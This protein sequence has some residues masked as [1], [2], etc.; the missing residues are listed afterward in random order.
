MPNRERQP[1]GSILLW[2][3]ALLVMLGSAVWQRKTGPTHPQKGEVE[4][5]G[6]TVPYTLLRSGT[7]G[8]PLRV[9]VG[10]P[11][12]VTG[13]I[14][15]RRYPTDEPFGALTMLRDGEVL[16]GLLPTQPPAGKL[17]YQLVLAG[18]FGL[19]RIPADEPV[20]MRFKDSVPA[21]ALIPH[22]LL[23]FLAM[24]IGVRAGL[25]A[26]L[27]RPETKRLA[28][29]TL[30]G[31]TVGGMIL[32]PVVQKYAFG[33]FWTGWPFGYDLTDNK[34]LVM[35][36][37]WL[38]AV[39]VL[40]YARGQKD[41]FARTVVAMATVV[42]IAVYLVPHSLRGSQLDYDKLDA[43]ESAHDAIGTGR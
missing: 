39:L 14:R 24:L 30:A 9:T 16:V 12:E 4:I 19:A 23:I 32:G 40:A 15:W 36:V 10:A 27:G 26:L 8:E 38:V 28:L 25:A 6:Q 3:L 11:P 43:G 35:F 2:I 31:I 22:I 1:A 18:S 21:W 5:A 41:R 37:A 20:V 34:T 29:V 7:S 13:T 33:A 17:E 42:M